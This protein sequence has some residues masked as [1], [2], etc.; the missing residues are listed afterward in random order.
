[1]L[2]VQMPAHYLSPLHHLI[3]EVAGKGAW[4]EKLKPARRTMNVARPA[5]YYDILSPLAAHVELWETT[6]FH[7]MNDA[8][9]ILNWIRGTGLR[10]FLQA[11]T[12]EDERLSFEAMVLQGIE[13]LYSPSADG[14]VLF[15]FPR[16]FFV[17]RR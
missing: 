1:M 15:P 13:K 10:P 12:T 6:Y 4:H 8:S 11:L 9:A 16:L 17:A 3:H 5:A 2:A 7:K 14:K